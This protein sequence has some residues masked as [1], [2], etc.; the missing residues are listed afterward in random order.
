VAGPEKIRKQVYDLRSSDLE[1]FPIWEHALAEEGETGQDEATVKPRPDLEEADSGEAMF[2]VRAEFVAHDGTRNDGYV[3][4]GFDFDL[5][6]MQPTIVTDKGQVNF[7][8][9]GFPP[10]PGAIENDCKVLG[11]TPEQPFPV[12]FRAVVKHGGA[13]LEGEVSAFLHL[14]T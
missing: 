9:G 10:K 5:S 7:W 8:Y 1:R 2:I 14:R 3:Y 6:Y 12:S 4:P 11:K 13:K